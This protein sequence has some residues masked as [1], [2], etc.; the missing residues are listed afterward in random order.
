MTGQPMH[1]TAPDDPAAWIGVELDAGPGDVACDTGYILAWLDATENA[2]P[3]YWDEGVAIEVAGGPMAPP[4][5][6]SVWM[7][8]LLFDPRRDDSIRPLELHFQVKDALQLPEGIVA[9][10]EITFYEPVRPGDVIATLQSVRSVSEPKSNRLGTGRFWTI[11]VTYTN[12]RGQVVGVESYD[13]FGYRRPPA[14]TDT[15][16]AA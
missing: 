13:M 12:Q 15:E 11:D 5:M 1:T 2:N 4:S 8:P 10:N 6:L 7:R 14:T 16:V 9:S 3:M